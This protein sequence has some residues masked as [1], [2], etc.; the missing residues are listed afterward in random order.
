MQTVP[1]APTVSPIVTTGSVSNI[2]EMPWRKMLAWGLV[3]H[4]LYAVTAAGAAYGWHPPQSCA[5]LVPTN[6]AAVTVCMTVT[7]P[8]TSWTV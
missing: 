3:F 4:S 1:Y 7:P 8:A 5:V 2:P 6:V